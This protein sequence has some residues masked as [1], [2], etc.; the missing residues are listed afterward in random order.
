[1]KR[2][3]VMT[4]VS[5]IALALAAG[6]VGRLYAETT[7][8]GATSTVEEQISGG[9]STEQQT[10]MSEHGL[11]AMNDI[12]MARVAVN[13]GDVDGARQLLDEAKTLLEKVKEEDVPVTVTTKVKVGDEPTK[14]ETVR[15]N[16]D[17]IPILGKTQLVEGY[18]ATVAD[19]PD[20][21]AAHGATKPGADDLSANASGGDEPAANEA[22]DAKP[23]ASERAAAVQQARQQMR[24]GDRAGAIETLRLVDLGLVSQVVSMPLADTSDHVDKALALIDEEQFYQAN[25]E[26]KRATEELVVQ[27]QI[28]VEPA[29]GPVGGDDTQAEPEQSG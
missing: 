16:P 27:T 29:A 18:A 25:L 20:A 11:A 4:S 9:P 1:M 8:P 26:L 14:E 24:D 23:T 15:G 7:Q 5:L 10:E 3:T 12:Q 13:D 19:R 2:F 21:E 28:V 17:L 6:T 22:S